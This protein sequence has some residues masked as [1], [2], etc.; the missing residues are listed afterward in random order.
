MSAPLYG[1]IEAGGTKW[2][3]AVA[4]GPNDVR[5][6]ARV[7]TTS[8]DE[9][10]GAVIAWLGR[11]GP[12]A[13][14][15]VASF[16]PVM[17]DRASSNWGC[18][19]VTPKP[20]WSHTD[21][22]GPLAR[23]FN[24]PVGFDTD[25]N[26]AALGE[27]RWG[28]GGRSLVYATIGTGIGGGTVIDGRILRGLSHPEMGHMRPRR[29]AGDDDFAGACPFHGDCLEG[30]A[31]GPAIIARW[32]ADLS[33]LPADHAGHRVI[34]DYLAQFVTSIRA[35]IMPERIVLGGGVMA[36]PGLLEQARGR[37]AHYAADYFPGDVRDIV[38]SPGLGERSGLLGAL[39]LA[40]QAAGF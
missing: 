11:H 32:G 34:A 14:I 33:Q 9:T 13:A 28:A 37:A 10:I 12:L 40:Q 26:A 29:A 22:A 38:V 16:G 24:C 5:A 39:I 7:P 1:L 4:T 25:V 17:L 30:L 2:I 35:L 36:A 31:S 15:G 3:A 21:I 19:T 6:V 18:I 27:Q 23:A 20:G 8:P